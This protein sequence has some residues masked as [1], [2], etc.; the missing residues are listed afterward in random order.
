[1]WAIIEDGKIVR[2][3]HRAEPFQYKNVNHPASV[4]LEPARVLELGLR[5][6]VRRQVNSPS[7]AA[8]VNH[9]SFTVET[10]YPTHIDR[11]VGWHLK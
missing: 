3:I 5:P 4:L 1:M 9:E 8:K 7:D 11:A 10:V 6:I 2:E